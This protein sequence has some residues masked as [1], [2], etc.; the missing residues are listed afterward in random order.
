M[1]SL[2]YDSDLDQLKKTLNTFLYYLI[3][4]ITNYITL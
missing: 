2:I 1:I 3:H 4:Q